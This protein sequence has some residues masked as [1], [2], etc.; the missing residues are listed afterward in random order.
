M[1]HNQCIFNVLFKQKCTSSNG[2]G[3]NII[4][5]LIKHATLSSNTAIAQ[6]DP[7]YFLKQPLTDVMGFVIGQACSINWLLVG[8]YKKNTL[9]LSTIVIN[10]LLLSIAAPLICLL[11]GN[12]CNIPRVILQRYSLFLPLIIR[13]SLLGYS[14]LFV[15]SRQKS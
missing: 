6:S 13:I 9:D 2:T 7:K 4:L 5:S 1:L 12:Y 3:Q 8:L 15:K 10:M 14:L 11:Y